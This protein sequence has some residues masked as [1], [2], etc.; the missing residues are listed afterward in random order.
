M[1]SEMRNLFFGT[2]SGKKKKKLK[3]LFLF[4]KKPRFLALDNAFLAK[5]R[6]AAGLPNEYTVVKCR[7]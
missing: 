3:E 1:G 6:L 4:A 7:F 5:P 2:A